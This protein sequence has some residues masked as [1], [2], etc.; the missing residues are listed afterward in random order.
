LENDMPENKQ[1][2]GSMVQLMDSFLHEV[3]LEKQASNLDLAGDAKSTH[4]SANVDDGTQAASEGSRSAENE[5]DVKKDVPDTINDESSKNQ[6]GGSDKPTDDQGTVSQSSDE[7]LKG[8]VDTPKKDHSK[9]MTDSGP[10]D[11]TFDGNWDKASAELAKMG[12][13]I[14][15]TLT[16]L[17]KQAGEEAGEAAPAPEQPA[18]TP[19]AEA[20]PQADEAPAAEEAPKTE[21]A[22]AADDKQASA[23]VEMYKQAAEQY[24]E[25]MEAGYAAATLLAQQLGFGSEKSAA[26]EQSLTAAVAGIRKEAE[27]DA[28]TY[29]KFLSGYNDAITKAA[30]GPEELAALANAG[31]GMPGAEMGGGLPMGGMEEMGGAPGAEELAGLGAEGGEEGGDEEAQLEEIAA[32]LDEAGITPEELAAAVAE[33]QGGE[34]PE[35]GAE[36]GEA[37]DLGDEG[38]EEAAEEGAEGME[39]PAAAGKPRTKR[40]STKKASNKAA[41]LKFMRANW[42]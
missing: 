9:S 20:A 32:A 31:G 28:E 39:V 18:E 8:N 26:D 5:A 1:T 17:L 33:A 10:G 41:L 27:A 38:S 34:V 40:A 7:G 3:D 37:M 19:A 13:D 23:E 21:D 29:L 4:P 36:E 6:Q 25:A 2:H 11:D 16:V 35:E 12:N 42:Q 30:Q 24:P 14:A 22:P 15:A